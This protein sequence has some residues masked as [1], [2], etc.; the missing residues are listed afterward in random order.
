R[1]PSATP[2]DTVTVGVPEAEAPLVDVGDGVEIYT[3]QNSAKPAFTGKISRTS[4]ARS[5]LHEGL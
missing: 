2:A 1:V 5:K 3:S 4:R